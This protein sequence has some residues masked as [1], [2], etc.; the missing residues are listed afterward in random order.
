MKLERGPTILIYARG[1]VGIE[2][3]DRD[4][5]AAAFGTD[6]DDSVLHVRKGHSLK[7]LPV[8]QHE[9]KLAFIRQR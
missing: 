1:R 5:A 3:A 7:L 2:V 9:R 8:V 4:R 6:I